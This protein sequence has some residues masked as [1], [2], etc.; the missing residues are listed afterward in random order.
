MQVVATF[1]KDFRPILK[2][3][4]AVL[5]GICY[6]TT[7]LHQ[8]IGTVLH[9]VSHF[10][11]MPGHVM[12]HDS[13]VDHDSFKEHLHIEHEIGVNDHEHGILDFF[14]SIFKASNDEDDSKDAFITKIKIDKHFVVTKNLVQSHLV[15]NQSN[16]FSEIVCKYSDG[17]SHELYD[18]PRYDF[19]G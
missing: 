8:Q 7:P 10:F 15:L 2:K 16:H 4:I 14:D 12:S 9:S 19:Q 6:L 13:F 1:L 5:M 17:Y 11:E 3:W 18:P